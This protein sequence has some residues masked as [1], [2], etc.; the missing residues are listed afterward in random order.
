GLDDLTHCLLAS[1][2]GCAGDLKILLSKLVGLSSVFS[3]PPHNLRAML[4]GNASGRPALEPEPPR[5][6][7]N[8]KPRRSGALTFRGR[9]TR[10][11]RYISIPSIPPIPPIP[12][13]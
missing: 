2:A 5:P 8:K 3:G 10:Q 11:A 4:T 12:W 1:R 9:V 6:S 13:A 7:G